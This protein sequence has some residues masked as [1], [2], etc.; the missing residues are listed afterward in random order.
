MSP[1]VALL[2]EVWDSVRSY[3]AAKERLH[4]AERLLRIFEEH[5]DMSDLKDNAHEF[6]KSMKAA[7]VNFYDEGYDEDDEEG[8]EESYY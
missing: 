4:E 2:H 3:I 6:D 7:I 1:E 8:S 5:I